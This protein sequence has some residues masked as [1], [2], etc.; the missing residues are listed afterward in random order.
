MC[1]APAGPG[2]VDVD[3]L[4]RRVVRSQRLSEQSLASYT[5]DQLEVETKYA[6][7]EKPKETDTRLFYV[8]SGDTPGEGS[9]EL[10]AVN[11]RPATGSEKQAVADEDAKAK[12]KRIERRAAEKARTTPAV[13]GDEEDPFIGARRLS[14]LLARYDYRIQREEV[15]DGRP[16]YVIRFSPR[17][18][19]KTS[20]LAEHA[21]SSLAGEIV[22]DAADYQIRRVD[23][24]LVQPVK[25]AGGLAA[26]VDDAV[27]KYQAAPMGPAHRWFPCVVDL[28]LHGKKALFLSLDVGY[29]YEFSNFK[30]FR[31][32]T[33]TAA[34]TQ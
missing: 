7:R 5:Y 27:V 1:A 32:D 9:R 12:R 18:G 2:F 17:R 19:L 31:V 30:T 29:R 11:G 16:C 3:A 33:E 20:G 15:V 23:A 10:V 8:F 21:L 28:R 6:K 25:V 13:S 4:I 14:D 26:R 22:V 34:S 24:F